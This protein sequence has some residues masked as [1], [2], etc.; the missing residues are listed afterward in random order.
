MP[1]DIDTYFWIMEYTG[2]VKNVKH[3]I[4]GDVTLIR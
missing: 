3:E 1:Q 2:G 4:K